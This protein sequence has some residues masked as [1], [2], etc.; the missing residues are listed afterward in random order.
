MFGEIKELL[1]ASPSIVLASVMIWFAVTKMRAYDKH[2]EEC[3]TKES[4][5]AVLAYRVGALETSVK[6]LNTD[7]H[8]YHAAVMDQLTKIAG[9]G[10]PKAPLP[11]AP[12]Q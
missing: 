7:V 8:N 3:K 12:H 2:I 1:G 4:G 11:H 6:T 9:T 5:E 10:D